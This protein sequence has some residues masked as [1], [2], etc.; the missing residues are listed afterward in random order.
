VLAAAMAHADPQVRDLFERFVPDEQRLKRLGSAVR[1]EQILTL[2]G[3]AGRGK[4]LF[5]KSTA[6]QCVNCHRVAG[7]GSTLGPDLT[8]I[9]KKLSRAQ[10]LESIL[11]PSKS[12][13]PKYVT[14]LVETT[15]GKIHTGLLAEKNERE[16]VLRTV[17]DQEIRLPVARVAVLAPQRNSLMPELLLRDLTAEQA[18]DLL[19]FLASLN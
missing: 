8:E 3:D 1:P 19:A 4:E 17:G 10:I 7:N 5:F 9:G 18:A 16:V 11:E 6:L 13:D 14:Y 2:K 15:D 12:I